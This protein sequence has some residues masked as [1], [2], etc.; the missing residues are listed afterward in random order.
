MALPRQIQVNQITGFSRFLVQQGNSETPVSISIN[1]YTEFILSGLTRT[2]SQTITTDNTY[3]FTFSSA[4]DTV[5]YALV[6]VLPSNVDYDP[7]SIVKSLTGF[8]V[9][10][11]ANLE[12][13][14]AV[15]VFIAIKNV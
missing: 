11:I 15:A 10:I 13:G 5:N 9:D 14:S 8:D 6:P 3:T 7:A 1:Q 2:A 12:G 4:L